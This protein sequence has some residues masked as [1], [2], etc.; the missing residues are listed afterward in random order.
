MT[1]ETEIE[2]LVKQGGVLG[3]NL[4]SSSTAEYCER[5]TDCL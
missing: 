1:E 3:P 2:E 4:C 5:N